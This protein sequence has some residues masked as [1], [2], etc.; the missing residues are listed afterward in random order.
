[1]LGIGF[2]AQQLGINALAGPGAAAAKPSNGPTP[3]FEEAYGPVSTPPPT[4]DLTS[5]SYRSSI[6]Q[7]DGI[8]PVTRSPRRPIHYVVRPL[9]KPPGGPDARQECICVGHL[10]NARPAIEWLATAARI[11]LGGSSRRPPTSV[12]GA[13][14]P[15]LNYPAANL[16][17]RLAA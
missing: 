17:G 2:A 9:N 14:R 6:T 10:R 3:G 12:F 16:W 1:M 8:K 4:T 13:A 15:C 7:P 5:V 11:G